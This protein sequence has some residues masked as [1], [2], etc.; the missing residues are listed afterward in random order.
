MVGK[1]GT[2][3]KLMGKTSVLVSNNRK[4]QSTIL[5]TPGC[6]LTETSINQGQEGLTK[7]YIMLAVFFK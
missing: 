6:D 3:L 4:P 2:Y 1:E 7:L 5:H